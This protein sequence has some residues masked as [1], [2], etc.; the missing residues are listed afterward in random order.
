[1]G[2]RTEGAP[3]RYR[4]SALRPPGDNTGIDQ[5]VRGKTLAGKGEQVHQDSTELARFRVDQSK[6]DQPGI[7]L[8]NFKQPGAMDQII[9]PYPLTDAGQDGKRGE[10]TQDDGRIAAAKDTASQICIKLT[11]TKSLEAS[12]GHTGRKIQGMGTSI[13]MNAS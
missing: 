5:P 10:Y 6:L 8:V 12:P 4:S 2:K 1:M 11:I 9:S 13:K 3:E 7:D